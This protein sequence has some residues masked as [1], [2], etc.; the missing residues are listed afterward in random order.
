M[1]APAAVT[2]AWPDGTTATYHQ[3]EL[4]EHTATP[5]RAGDEPDVKAYALV[6]R[7]SAAPREADGK[8]YTY[9]NT[10]APWAEKSGE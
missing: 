5:V 4:E 3:V 6:I 2:I 1:S 7:G 8:F 9:D 10:S